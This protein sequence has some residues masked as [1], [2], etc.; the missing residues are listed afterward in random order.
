[1]DIAG[2]RRVGKTGVSRSHVIAGTAPPLKLVETIPH[3]PAMWREPLLRLLC[4]A[5]SIRIDFG[6]YG[7]AAWEA[8]TGEKYL[9]P[10]SDIDLLWRP[11]RVDQLGAGI[12][13]LAG[14]EVATGLR[15][16][17]EILFGDDDAVAWREW[18]ESASE[19]VPP[20]VLVKSLAGPR[21]CTRAELLA[22]AY[23]NEVEA[24]QCL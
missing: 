6:V 17:G 10:Q 23:Q 20:R 8:L 21:L 15:A 11:T 24:A 22:R 18:M 9:T 4:G 12:A 14:W 13:L 3:L 2:V 16:D 7:S 5:E 19:P 1:M